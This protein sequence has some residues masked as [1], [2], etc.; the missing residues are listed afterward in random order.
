MFYVNTIE[1]SFK[2]MSEITKREHKWI[3]L[4]LV[5]ETRKGRSSLKYSS[6]VRGSTLFHSGT[7]RC[8]TVEDRLL[9]YINNS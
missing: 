2:K 4:I 8:I 5:E 1:K 7:T 3:D 9:T 6:S